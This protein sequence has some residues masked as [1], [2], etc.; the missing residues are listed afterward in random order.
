MFLIYDTIPCGTGLVSALFSL[1]QCLARLLFIHL[2]HE[3][4]YLME[5]CN[6]PFLTGRGDR[7]RFSLSAACANIYAH[8]YTFITHRFSSHRSS[9]VWLSGKTGVLIVPVLKSALTP[10]LLMRTR[11]DSP[12]SSRFLFPLSPGQGIWGTEYSQ[13]KENLV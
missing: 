3:M 13:A 1:R 4:L 2:L 5:S 10:S 7:T 8:T 9:S 11:T 12:A 6:S